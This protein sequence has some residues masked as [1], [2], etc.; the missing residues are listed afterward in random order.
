MSLSDTSRK[1]KEES[2]M[3]FY[4]NPKGMTKEMW[5]LQYGR[6]VRKEELK[7]TDDE[8]PVILVDNGPFTAVGIAY[9]QDELSVFL[10]EDGRSKMFY[11]CKRED[12]ESFLPERLRNGRGK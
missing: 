11:M 7:I 6:A 5:I 10:R 3:G 9:S 8:M 12:L 1:E 2:V 4:V